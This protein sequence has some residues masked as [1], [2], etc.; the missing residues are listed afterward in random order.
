VYGHG[1]HVA[2]IIALTAPGAKIMP[3]RILDANGEGSLWR[4]KDAMLYAAQ[5][6]ATIINMSFGYPED[7][8]PQ[9]NTFL[10]DLFNSCDDVVV[11]G[12]QNF[13]DDDK[14]LIVAAAGNGGQIGN[15]SA[16]VYP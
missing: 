14:L 11:P 6:G 13:F 3:I 2:G 8:T 5:H 1:T 15:G 10:N 16:R 9:S 4:V 7:F 12:E